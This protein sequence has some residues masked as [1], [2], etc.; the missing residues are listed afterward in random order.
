MQER[1]N[2]TKRVWKSTAENT[3][4]NDTMDRPP[5]DKVAIAPAE[6]S[7]CAAAPAPSHT[8]PRIDDLPAEL[9]VMILHLIGALPHVR[10]VCASWR[11]AVD[12]LVSSGRC[13]R[14]TPQEYMGLLAR[15]NSKEMIVWAR[16]QGCP[17]DAKACIEAALAGHLDLLQWLL[18]NNCPSG[19]LTWTPTDEWRLMPG[20]SARRAPRWVWHGALYRGRTDVVQWLLVSEN[21]W[22]RDA[23]DHA[24]AGGQTT[25]LLMAREAGC[26]WSAETCCEAARGG[27]LG[28][29][30]WL[31]AKGCPWNEDVL[32]HSLRAGHPHVAEWAIEH[33][34]PVDSTIIGWAMAS[35]SLGVVQTLRRLGH[36]W[37]YSARNATRRGHLDVLKWAV[38]NGCPLDGT[39]CDEAAAGGR[40][41]VLEWLRTSG[42]PWGVRT[43]AF[44]AREG[45]LD[46]LKWLVA[47]GCPWDSSVCSCAASG[48]RLDI[49]QWA[50][51]NGC[52]WNEWTC[53]AARRH[54]DILQWARANGCPWDKNMCLSAAQGGA[55][56]V[57]QWARANGCPWDR[58]KCLAGAERYY[59]EVADWIAAQPE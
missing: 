9:L 12:Y 48:G 46:I 4:D 25:A 47:S 21:E 44:A 31:V 33:G 2:K 14:P 18:V 42:C 22:P 43:C 55:L 17:W 7:A 23:C 36:E 52:P 26:P 16:A 8:G 19:T 37:G 51:A 30:Q 15:R 1:K 34:C 50:R 24:A 49:L 39:A 56:G 59:P 11:C 3:Y 54:P 28:T 20:T 45:H 13:H 10:M 58:Q 6:H 53:E 38:A 29:L 57:L 27:H 32:R 35:G 40:L 5:T 41:E